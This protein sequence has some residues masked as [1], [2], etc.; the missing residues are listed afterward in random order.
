METIRDNEGQLV[1]RKSETNATKA[2]AR[3][4]RDN[5]QEQRGT[6]GAKEI[7][8]KR[9][10]ITYSHHHDSISFACLGKRNF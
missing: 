9:F 2:K 10:L 5:G 1:P 6:T 8:R 3:D 4:N 7:A